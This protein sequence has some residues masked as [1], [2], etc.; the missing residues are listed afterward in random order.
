M[1][2]SGIRR[3]WLGY[4]AVSA[5]LVVL[6]GSL[7][8]E[9]SPVASAAAGC[10]PLLTV[11]VVITGIRLNRPARKLPWYL[12]IASLTATI[13]GD[14]VFGIYVAH[15]VTP[16]PSLADPF[17]LAGYGLELAG[18]MLLVNGTHW[19]RDRDSIID[20]LMVSVGLGLAVWLLFLRAL[21]APGMSLDVRLVAMAYPLAGLLMLAGVIR[22]CTSSVRRG[23][24]FWQLVVAVT[25]QGVLQAAYQWQ[26]AQHAAVGGLA[27]LFM[28]FSVLLGGAA[29]HPSMAAFGA[30][31]DRPA[32]NATPRRVMLIGSACLLSPLLLIANGIVD[33]GRV[34]WLAASICC[35]VVFLLVIMRMVGLIR[36]VQDQADRLESI[37]YRD[38]LTGIAN[39]RSWDAELERRL[40]IARRA[41]DTLIVGLIDLDHF[42]RYNDLLGHPAGDQLLREAAT[43]WE[44]Q[45]R[46]ED[47]I[48]RYG[49]EEFGLILHGRLRD[50]AIV[51]DRL[52]DATPDGQTFSAGLALWTGDESAAELTARVD[53]ALYTAK[54]EGRDQYSVTGHPAR[55]D[56]QT[57]FLLADSRPRNGRVPDSLE[58]RAVKIEQ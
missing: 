37:A 23:P 32:G 53:A 38:A 34:D 11:A 18:L 33:R 28:V 35:I 3:L 22:M 20:T 25:V 17:W 13:T 54:R 49:G 42:K 55:T 58:G 8:P 40:A 4:L 15:G 51:M 1:A 56:Q 43:A 52:R 41:G 5:V 46:A 36:T 44:Q 19:R 6:V 47:L 2:V 29:L 50:A 39:R 16:F 7:V 24:A 45:L 10:Y 14:V 21:V 9:S 12:L 27:P 30:R 57:N 48:A 31:D 26:V